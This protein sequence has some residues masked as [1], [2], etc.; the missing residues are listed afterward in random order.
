MFKMLG[1]VVGLY[2]GYGLLTGEVYGK[3]GAGGRTF[4]R[5]EDARGNGST[6][7]AY[8]LLSSRCSS[9]SE[10]AGS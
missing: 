6:L 4:R 3:S 1:V 5:D 8:A 10:A 9:S 2:V 7:V